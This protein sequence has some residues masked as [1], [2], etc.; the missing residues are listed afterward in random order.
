MTRRWA[1][2]TNWGELKQ[3]FEAALQECPDFPP[4]VR[5]DGSIKRIDAGLN[6]RN[7]SFRI[8]ADEP[9]P[10]QSHPVCVAR[11][12]RKDADPGLGGPLARLKS[13]AAVMKQLAAHDLPISVPRF[14]RFVGDSAD[15]P[16]GLIETAVLGLPLDYI[17]KTETGKPAVIGHV[18][19]VAAAIH[20][21]DAARFEGLPRAAD[22]RSDILEDLGGFD[23]EFLE[24]DP[25]AAAVAA[26]VR[27]HL[28]EGRGVV[29]VHGDLLPQNLLW[30][31]DTDRL[32]VVDWEYAR[33][34]DP[35]YDLAIVCRG[36]Q[37]PLGCPHGR[38]M[39]LDLYHEAGG[40]PIGRADVHTHELLMVLRWLWRAIKAERFGREG[41][42]PPDFYRSRLRAV[43]R[44][45][46]QNE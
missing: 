45:T 2:K 19:R 36:S 6:H 13:E 4:S 25:E 30:D 26:W 40:A 20:R 18:A 32:G 21:L 12:I 46:E 41:G 1:D 8:K 14:V 23:A 11:L 44:R 7:Y 24:R 43:L 15:R 37:Q 35:A 38:R 33:L 34:G 39:L 28:P 5:I 22:S 9:V 10:N 16:T 29:L 42:Q 3:D 31:M 17:V 27:A